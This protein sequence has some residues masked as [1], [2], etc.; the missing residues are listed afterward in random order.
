MNKYIARSRRGA[1]AKAII[2]K[3]GLPRMVV[4]RS[5]K[6]IYAQIVTAGEQGDV[7]VA[8][9]S[10][11]DKD[12]RTKVE[13]SKTEQAMQ[14]GKSLAERAKAKNISQVAFDRSGYLYHG[15]VKAIADGAREAGLEF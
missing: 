5:S 2:R 7:V 10:T 3:S 8:S 12:L 14:V 6:H 13:G 1:K 9:C 4:Y 11:L 15:R